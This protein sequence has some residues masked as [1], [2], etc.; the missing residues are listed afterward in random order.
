MNAPVIDSVD[1]SRSCDRAGHHHLAT[2]L[3]GA[4][5]DVHHPVG[6]PDGVLV[7]LDHDQRVA[8]IAQPGE[9]LDQPV[10]VPLVQ[11]DRRLVEHVQHPDQPGAD[12]GGQPDPLRLAAGQGGRRPVQRQIVEADVQ[13]E[14][15]PRVRPP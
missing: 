6:G 13:Q 7:V 14:P 1:A 4:R 3:A 11:P 10:V 8:E 9:G 15:E 5:P 12:L 2:V